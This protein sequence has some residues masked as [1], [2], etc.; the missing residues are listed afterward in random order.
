MHR[1]I[2]RRAKPK[3]LKWMKIK[4]CGFPILTYCTRRTPFR[5]SLNIFLI[6]RSEKKTVHPAD[7]VNFYT[8]FYGYYDSPATSTS[9]FFYVVVPGQ[10]WYTVYIHTPELPPLSPPPPSSS[11]SPPHPLLLV[12]PP[13]P[14]IP[15]LRLL[16]LPSSSSSSCFPLYS[17]SSQRGH[18]RCCVL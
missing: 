11:S 7:D 13:S 9:K 10:E 14:P 2:V 16:P 12:S 3:A 15:P 6:I 4:K 5:G 17:C 8:N 18:T 1:S